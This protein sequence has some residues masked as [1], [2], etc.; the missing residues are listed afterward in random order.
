MG[1]LI[2]EFEINYWEQGKLVV[3]IDEA[4]R[5]PMAGPC[6]VSGVIF[7]KGF[8]DARIN[9]S[10]QLSENQRDA[11]VSIIESNALWTFTEI[12]PVDVID[13]DNIYRATQNAMKKIALES[14]ADIVLTDAMPLDDLTVPCEAIVKGDA[15][16]LSIA[17]ASILAKTVRDGLMKVYDLE[18][19]EYGFAKHKGY[20][21][22]Q[23]KEAILKFGRCPIH[24]K[25]FRFKDET[26]ISFDI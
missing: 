4:G 17:A 11:L 19:P 15:R 9:D 25:S 16:S 6:V 23:H 14:K 5:G 3:G 24:R 12:I 1:S 10:K 18:F 13:R 22:K 8:Y 21:T 20:G 26:Q 7:P 2:E